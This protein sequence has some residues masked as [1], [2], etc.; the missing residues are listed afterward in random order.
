LERRNREARSLAQP[1]A[2][3]EQPRADNPTRPSMHVIFVEPVFPGNQRRFPHA[4]KEAGAKVSAIGE[5]PAN[6]LDD[7][8]KRVLDDYEQVPSV[9]HEGALLEAVRRLQSRSWVDRLEA[10][11]E[12]HILPVARV[13][14]ACG[15]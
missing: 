9:V 13:R 2:T 1:A 8:T 4:L 3:S 11:V 10:T 12:A 5:V 15:I 6:Y 14:E 7:E